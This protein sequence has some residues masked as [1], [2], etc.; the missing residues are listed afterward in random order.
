[1]TLPPTHPIVDRLLDGADPSHLKVRAQILEL[2]HG[3]DVQGPQ[4]AHHAYG[5]RLLGADE[6]GEVLLMRW[7]AGRV[8]KPH[9]HDHASGFMMMIEGTFIERTYTFDGH[10]LSLEDTHTAHSPHMVRFE[11]SR[12]H[13]MTSPNGGLSLHVY[14]PR[15]T[16]MRVFDPTHLRT[17]VVH[18]RCGAWV[19]RDLTMILEIDP[20]RIP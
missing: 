9:D 8:C 20:W 14:R 19:P 7:G 2:C 4:A 16:R 12:I 1:M 5:R 6:R 10:A 17:L 3:L 18:E 15:I 13:D 11:T